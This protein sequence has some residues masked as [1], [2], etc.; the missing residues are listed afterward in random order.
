MSGTY[1]LVSTICCTLILA[2]VSSYTTAGTM[3]IISDQTGDVPYGEF[4]IQEVY[5]NVTKQTLTIAI[6]LV[7]KPSVPHEVAFIAYQVFMSTDEVGYPIMDMYAE[8]LV[9]YLMASAGSNEE[10][11]C[12]YKY[13]GKVGEW[14]WSMVGYGDLKV[15]DSIMYFT[16]PLNLIEKPL[17]RILI[18]TCSKKKDGSWLSDFCPDVGSLPLKKIEK[19]KAEIPYDSFC[20]VYYGNINPQLFDM[21]ARKGIYKLAILHPDPIPIPPIELKRADIKVIAYLNILGLPIGLLGRVEKEHPEWI[22]RRAD[23]EPAKYWYGQSFMCNLAIKSWR[24]YLVER[25]VTYVKNGFDGVF[26]DDVVIDPR[27]LGPPLYDTP[28]Y[29]EARYGP[30]LDH[31]VELVKEIKKATNGSLVIYNAGWSQVN[32]RLLAV[33]DGLMLES[34]LGCWRG[35]VMNPEYYYRPWDEILR[36]SLLA[37]RYAEQGKIIVALSYGPDRKTALNCFVV[38]RLFDFFFAFSTP[39]LQGFTDYDVLNIRLG[40]PL[41]KLRAIG[42]VY[43]REYENGIVVFN[44]SDKDVEI[45]LKPSIEVKKL[46]DLRDYRELSSING[47]IK[48]RLS[49]FE[50]TVLLRK[51][52]LK[53]GRV[54]SL[55]LYAIVGI[56]I[57]TSIIILTWL[58]RSLKRHRGAK[59]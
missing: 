53:Q 58:L 2:M 55:K 32:D 26:L 46:V 51:L 52:A 37:Q 18:C 14:N 49:A 59:S 5:V 34:Y 21:I 33:T 30:W 3:L 38:A 54:D 42:N 35:N 9:E 19:P 7:K 29:D 24:E 31:L 22:L 20:L 1:Y 10:A 11:L 16:I 6:R 25:A 15:R 48:V 41:G 4:D 17:A 43:V 36:I 23:G 28:V 44:P 13:S 56:P 39:D 50:G 47:T 57:V 27:L 12:I 8:Y 40:R 45:V